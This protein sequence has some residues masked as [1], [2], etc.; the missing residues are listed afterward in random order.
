MGQRKNGQGKGEKLHFKLHEVY[1]AKEKR[2]EGFYM[3][4]KE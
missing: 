2:K 1:V 3:E 4:G